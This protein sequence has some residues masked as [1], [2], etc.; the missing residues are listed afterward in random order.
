MAGAGSLVGGTVAASVAAGTVAASVTAG[1]VGTSV[2][3]GMVGAS[4]AAGVGV[5]LAHPARTNAA[6]VIM[7]I[8]VSKCFL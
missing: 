2:A 6:M 1:T 8:S 3:T 5:E 7:L 4:V